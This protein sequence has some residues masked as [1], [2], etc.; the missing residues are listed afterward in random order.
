MVTRL[1][2]TAV[3][4][5]AMAVVLGWRSFVLFEKS[6]HLGSPINQSCKRLSATAPHDG[7]WH[8]QVPEH[9]DRLMAQ[10]RNVVD[11]Y[12]QAI[13]LTFGAG[14]VLFAWGAA[15]LIAVSRDHLRT[16]VPDPSDA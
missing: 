6:A 14:F 16:K 3:L 10:V 15:M 4:L 13:V 11:A 12:D 7:S 1:K 9:C 8:A 2:W 5:M